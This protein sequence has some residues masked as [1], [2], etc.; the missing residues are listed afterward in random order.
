MK[1]S[2]LTIAV[3]IALSST[4]LTSQAY[5]SESAVEQLNITD[6]NNSKHETTET[7]G[8]AG[9]GIGAATGAIVAG[10]IG[11]VVGGLIGAIAGS[12]QETSD[13]AEIKSQDETVVSDLSEHRDDFSDIIMISSESIEN[14]QTDT[15]GNTYLAQLGSVTPVVENEF[16]TQQEDI[17][18]ILV[19]DLSLDVYF[20]SGSTDIEKFYPARLSAIADLVNTMDNLELHL[21]G[22]TDR[23]GDKTQN[24][25]LANERIDKVRQQL[26]DAGVENS[27]IVSKAFG[28]AKMKSAAGNL[29]AYTFDRRVVIRFE[30]LSSRSGTA[31]AALSEIPAAEEVNVTA[32]IESHI[33]VVADATTRF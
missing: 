23:R 18:N 24:M 19:S 2:F 8:Y 27:R 33:P 21:D 12:N 16:N 26:I 13:Q 25:A 11:L 29:E 22:Y 1:K 17:M 31:T 5:A 6:N 20:R 3:S 10:P 7:Y 30:R 9:I 28:E 15:G 4:V 14:P 32:N